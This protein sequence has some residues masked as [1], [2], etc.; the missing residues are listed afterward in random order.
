MTSNSRV[1]RILSVQTQAGKPGVEDDDPAVAEWGKSRVKE[2]EATYEAESA[3]EEFEDRE[4][5]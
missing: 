3:R 4:Y 1:S 2:F 5:R